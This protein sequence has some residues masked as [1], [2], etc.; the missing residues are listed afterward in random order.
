MPLWLGTP[1]ESILFPVLGG[2]QRPNEACH[3]L[4]LQLGLYT[5]MASCL[6]KNVIA[7]AWP[8]VPMKRK[9]LRVYVSK[10]T[11]KLRYG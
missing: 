10:Q 11:L 4:M 3:F 2:S 1:T 6:G 9:E 5:A 7:E 8:Q